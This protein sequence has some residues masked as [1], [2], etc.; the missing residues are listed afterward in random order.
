MVLIN[1]KLWSWIIVTIIF[2]SYNMFFNKEE[3][4]GGYGSDISPLFRGTVSFIL[5]M[6]F[7]IIWLLLT[8]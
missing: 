5:Y 8:R 3:R 7:W 1:L 4:S 2:V 6:L